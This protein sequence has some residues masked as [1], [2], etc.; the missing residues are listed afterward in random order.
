M[1]R[2]AKPADAKELCRIYNYYVKNSIATFEDEPINELEMTDRINKTIPRFPWLVAVKHEK[3]V[4]YAYATEWKPRTAYKYTVETTVYVDHENSEKGIGKALYQELLSML[5]QYSFR[6]V[7]GSIA[8]PNEASIMLH[9]HLGF[10]RV[11]NLKKVG[12]KFGQWIDV[13][14]WQKTL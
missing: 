2:T 1:I 11:G 9:E 12:H 13:G 8:L 5:K 10:S 3:I 4:G 6:N 7:I 14:I